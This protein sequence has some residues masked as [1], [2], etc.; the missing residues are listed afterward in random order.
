MLFSV[1]LRHNKLCNGE[2]RIRTGTT[3]KTPRLLSCTGY[4]LAHSCPKGLKKSAILISHGANVNL[5]DDNGNTALNRADG[6]EELVS[7]L[8]RAGA[9]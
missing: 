2:V 5:K 3:A 8:K 4:V 7:L 1:A 9:K 6:N